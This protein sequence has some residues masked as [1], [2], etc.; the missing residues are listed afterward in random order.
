[1]ALGWFSRE[2]LQLLALAEPA[3]QEHAGDADAGG[4]HLLGGLDC[5]LFLDVGVR[6]LEFGVSVVQLAGHLLEGRVAFVDFGVGQVQLGVQVADDVVGPLDFGVGVGDVA[7]GLVNGGVVLVDG[8]ALGL[9]GLVAVQEAVV[10]GLPLLAVGVGPGPGGVD[11]RVNGAD[12]PDGDQAEDTEP[13]YGDGHHRGGNA[14]FVGF[15]VV[16]H[17][18]RSSC[19]LDWGWCLSFPWLSPPLAI[20]VARPLALAAAR[21]AGLAGRFGR[22]K[23]G[24]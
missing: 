10:A 24:F 12:G 11:P 18:D 19:D 5:L 20:K 22:W 9:E 16:V 1:M 6:V 21:F 7:V 15:A 23:P 13:D 4:S 14:G 3:E 17:V 2:W 8:D